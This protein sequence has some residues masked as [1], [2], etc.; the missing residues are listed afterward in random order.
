VCTLED[1]QGGLWFGTDA[2]VF[3]LRRK[4][5]RTYTEKDGLPDDHVWSVQEGKHGRIWIG[6]DH[7][8]AVLEHGFFSRTNYPWHGRAVWETRIGKTVVSDGNQVISIGQTSNSF[9]SGFNPQDLGSGG[10]RTLYE[11]GAGRIWVGTDQGAA[12]VPDL[13]NPCV[14]SCR[15]F[16]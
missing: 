3:L 12:V 5:C 10:A 8:T 13:S 16:P 11:D 9:T 14:I 2:G 7:G 1:N 6:T 15:S 4:L